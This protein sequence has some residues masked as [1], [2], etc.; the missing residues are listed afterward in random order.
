[1]IA[2]DIP[3][4]P[5]ICRFGSDLELRFEQPLV[6]AFARTQHHPVLAE[7]DRMFVPIGGD[8]PDGENRHCNPVIRPSIACIFRAK[9]KAGGNDDPLST[10]LAADE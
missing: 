9:N 5:Q 7:G 1:V 8:M 6:T 2:E 10:E 3:D 4:P